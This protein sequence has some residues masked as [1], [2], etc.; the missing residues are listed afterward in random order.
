MDGLVNMAFFSTAKVVMPGEPRASVH[1]RGQSWVSGATNS[2]TRASSRP[3][4]EHVAYCNGATPLAA[5][6][7][8]RGES[9]VKTSPTPTSALDRQSSNQPGCSV[10]WCPSSL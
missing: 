10:S 8:H 7:P 1:A 6:T 2:K 4:F 5:Q 9:I 3:A